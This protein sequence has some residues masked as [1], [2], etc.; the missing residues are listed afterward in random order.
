[1]EEKKQK[2]M[3]KKNKITK[4]PILILTVALD[5]TRFQT[6]GKSCMSR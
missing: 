5:S 2:H 3:N 6:K 1:M 4:V